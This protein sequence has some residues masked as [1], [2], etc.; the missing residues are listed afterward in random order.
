MNDIKVLLAE[1]SSL[2][3]IVGMGVEMNYQKDMFVGLGNSAILI[4]NHSINFF[5]KA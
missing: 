2:K 4:L 1:S 3:D 5:S